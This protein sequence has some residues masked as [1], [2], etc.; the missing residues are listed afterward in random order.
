MVSIVSLMENRERQN[1]GE[2]NKTK[3]NLMSAIPVRC[4]FSKRD[5]K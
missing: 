5:K 2:R 4:K 1:S 3:Q